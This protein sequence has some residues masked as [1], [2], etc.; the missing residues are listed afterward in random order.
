MIKSF[1]EYLNTL[2]HRQKEIPAIFAS[3][4]GRHDPYKN[5]APKKK[6]S[7]PSTIKES[8]AKPE[9]D[10]IKAN[11]LYEHGIDKSRVDK[12][13]DIPHIIIP[14][15]QLGHEKLHQELEQLHGHHLTDSDEFSEKI[16]HVAGYVG[17]SSDI[18]RSLIEIHKAKKDPTDKKSHVWAAED[19]VSKRTWNPDRVAA[20]IKEHS[21]HTHNTMNEMN[22][23]IENSPPAHREFHVFT[24]VGPNFDVGKLRKEGNDKVHLPAFTSTSINPHIA[25]V[26]S[27]DGQQKEHK[28]IIRI[29]IPQGSRHGTYIGSTGLAGEQ[30]YVLKHG[31]TLQF[32]GEPRMVGTKFSRDKYQENY[33][34][35]DADLV[36]D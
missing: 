11:D 1:K 35:H 18:N 13:E 4:H 28:E 10:Y 32:K 6:D 30:E 27:W 25:R 22:R 31:K 17:D 16:N 2:L 14:L 3:I 33:M 8:R 15:H 5:K 9:E 34:V 23:V 26:F 12:G 29:R 21:D 20:K 19:Y 36:D 24:G 7:P